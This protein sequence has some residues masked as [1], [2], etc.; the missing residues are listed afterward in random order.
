MRPTAAIALGCVLV[1][2]MSTHVYPGGFLSRLAAN[3]VVVDS[4]GQAVGGAV[5]GVGDAVQVVLQPSG[6]PTTV[7]VTPTEIKGQTSGGVFWESFDCSGIALLI[8]SHLE[9]VFGGPAFS[10]K[11]HI[12]V[13]KTEPSQL[14]INHS[15]I[16]L[17][18]EDLGCQLGSRDDLRFVEALTFPLSIFDVFEPPFSIVGVRSL[19]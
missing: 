16:D 4:K 15:F 18:R 5:S 10:S 9:P 19:P 1:M 13:P 6:V 7:L 11:T 8:A 14:R 3:P 12:Y 2:C 17:L